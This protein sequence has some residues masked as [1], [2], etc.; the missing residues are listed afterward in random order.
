MSRESMTMKRHHEALEGDDA[1]RCR[2]E[3]E[4]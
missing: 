2:N 3:Q 1:Y 4:P